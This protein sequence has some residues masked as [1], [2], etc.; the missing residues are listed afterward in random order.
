MRKDT[1]DDMILPA[2]GIG[3]MSSLLD[4]AG[5]D[6]RP[7]FEVCGLAANAPMPVSGV[8]TALQ[9]LSFER[10]FVALT[11]GRRAGFQ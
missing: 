9:E 7:A 3:S 2:F 6:S 4:H 10:A 1:P 8:V 5:I 11:Q